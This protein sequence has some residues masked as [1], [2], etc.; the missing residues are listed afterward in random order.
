[1][2]NLPTTC[3]AASSKRPHPNPLIKPERYVEH[4]Y[5]PIH[6]RYEYDPAGELSRTLDKLRGET[7]YEYEAN[8]QLLAR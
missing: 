3:W 5:N 6:R 2:W 7:Q 8:G 1:N 4:A